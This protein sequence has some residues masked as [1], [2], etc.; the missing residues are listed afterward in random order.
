[1]AVFAARGVYRGVT[2]ENE[3]A[4]MVTVLIGGTGSYEE[5]AGI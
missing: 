5:I 3:T 2:P 1:M 4:K